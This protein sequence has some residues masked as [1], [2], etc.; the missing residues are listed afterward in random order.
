MSFNPNDVD[1]QTGNSYYS[2]TS[3]SRGHKRPRSLTKHLATC[4]YSTNAL[5]HSP[6]ARLI[7][8]EC[9][10]LFQDQNHANGKYYF[11]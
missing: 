6:S 2:N 4:N 5:N 10:K 9:D 11:R 8:C 7:N 3:G 1:P